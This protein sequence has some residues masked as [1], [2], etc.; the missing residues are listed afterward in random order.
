MLIDMRGGGTKGVHTRVGR[1]NI[2]EKTY[3]RGIWNI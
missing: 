1:G 3:K 2:K